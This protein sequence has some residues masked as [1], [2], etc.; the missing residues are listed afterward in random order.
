MTGRLAR[1]REVPDPPRPA[2]PAR[3]AR[4][5]DGPVPWL[6]PSARPDRNQCAGGRLT[7]C[8][9]SPTSARRPTT[10]TTRCSWP[11][12][13][14][15]ISPAPTATSAIALTALLRRVR[16]RSTPT[17]SRSPARRRPLPPPIAAPDPRLPAHAG[18]RPRSLRPTRLARFVRRVSVPGSSHPAARRRA[19][20]A[21]DRR[22]ADRVAA[23]RLRFVGSAGA[24]PE[25]RRRRGA[26]PGRRLGAARRPRAAASN[27]VDRRGAG[28]L[29]RGRVGRSAATQPPPRPPAPSPAPVASAGS[30]AQGGGS[31]RGTERGRRRPESRH[32][33][34][35]PRRRHRAQA[36]SIDHGRRAPLRRPLVAARD[37]LGRRC[38][39]CGDRPPDRRS[40]ARRE[41]P[42]P[43]RRRPG[44]S[45]GPARGYTPSCPPNA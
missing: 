17:S 41:P 33:R 18:R 39:S 23:V 40:P 24:A 35:R 32:R 42:P 27:G 6:T 14:P 44:H 22:A 11:R 7:P 8:L 29:R 3:P 16:R 38:S 43:D 30:D 36:L 19:R 20:D 4:R 9:T 2:R 26:Q 12:S 15:A 45:G 37:R 25:A 31:A 1:H 28:R 21:R 5:P 13:P 34:R 10:A